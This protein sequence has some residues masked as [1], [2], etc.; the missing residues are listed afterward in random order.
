MNSVNKK[1]FIMTIKSA[2]EMLT[3]VIL[4]IDLTSIQFFKNA[5]VLCLE[6]LGLYNDYNYLHTKYRLTI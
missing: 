6:I 5:S 3:G 4:Q 1:V 2:F